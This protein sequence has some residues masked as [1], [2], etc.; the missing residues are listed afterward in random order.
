MATH[1]TESRPVTGPTIHRLTNRSRSFYRL[2]GPFLARRE[3]IA[4]IGGPIWDDDDK[5]W[6]IA[7]V[8]GAVIG[9]C[10]A[11]PGRSGRTVYQSAYVAPDW[12]K[13]GVYRAL[14]RAR[15]DEFPGP[16]QAVCTAA[17]LPFFLAHGWTV[18]GTRGSFTRVVT[19]DSTD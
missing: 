2:M 14:W 15:R 17:A 18:A 3:V 19:G 6:F 12:R 4:E 13:Q 16:A 10:A 8:D 1:L 9:F 5:V 7:L 11:R